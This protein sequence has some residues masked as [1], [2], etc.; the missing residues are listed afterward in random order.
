MSY[1]K[2]TVVTCAV[3]L[4]VL[5]VF[6]RVEITDGCNYDSDCTPI[7]YLNY[8]KIRRYCCQRKYFSNICLSS[9]VG[10]SCDSDS[11]CGPSECCDATTAKCQTSY[12]ES[13]SE[14]EKGI[15]WILPVTIAGSIVGALFVCLIL[16]ILRRRATRG[17][18]RAGVVM[19]QPAAAGT[20]VIANQQ[21]QQAHVEQQS[22]PMYSQNAPPYPEPTSVALSSETAEYKY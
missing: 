19:R 11:A 6:S 20:T 16:S 10:Q 9:C 8:R 4:A 17:S 21:Q 5:V 7:Y 14:Q 18:A 22:L 13:L 15:H 2:K 3:Y 1:I 12:C